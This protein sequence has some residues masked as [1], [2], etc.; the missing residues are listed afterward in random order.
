MI[1]F[2]GQ[3]ARALA[4][5][6]KVARY[7]ASQALAAGDLKGAR[8]QLE[9][10][11]ARSPDDADALTLLAQVAANQQD[12]DEAL[13]LLEAAAALDP[14]PQR[15]AVLVNN[16]QMAFDAAAAL[17]RIERMPESLRNLLDVR[18]L[19]AVLV[20][21]LG[22][23]RRE[24]GIFEVLIRTHG[25]NP[26]VWM[27]YAT[28]LKVAGRTDEAAAAIQRAIEILPTYGEAYWALANF[29]SYRFSDEEVAAMQASLGLGINDFQIMH[30]HFALGV[31]FE[32]RGDYRQAFAHFDAGNR[33]RAAR[34][35]PG[36][37]VV[38]PIV[39]AAIDTLSPTFFETRR[40]HGHP[41]DEPIFVIGLH[42]SGSTLIEQIL[43][44]HPMIEG[45]S[46]LKTMPRL[47]LRLERDANAAGRSIWEEM[48]RLDARALHELGAEYMERTRP[49]RRGSESRFV[50]KLPGNWLQVS[51]IRL[52]FPNAKIIDARRHPMACGLSNFKQNYAAG[53]S[54]S[55]SLQTIGLLYRDY[56]RMMEHL[57]RVQPGA[58]HHVVNERLID[59]FESEVR[60]L[61]DFVGVP[62]DP[63]CLEFHRNKRAVRT[64][65]A[66]QVRRPINS[67]GAKLWRHY[68]PWLGPL[69]QALGPALDEWDKTI[70]A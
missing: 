4:A 14:S 30:F 44:S 39:D 26:T 61:L 50:D 2:V 6:G 56:L 21:D 59:D 20:G 53:M 48:Q 40:G 19:E 18:L 24:L 46:E 11:L 43:A 28:P 70:R 1:G 23:Q 35:P 58:V 8:R 65:S 38:T 12:L 42:R 68:E 15:L 51:L 37:M 63:A 69:K 27:N 66:E 31:A 10:W 7:Y 67:E 29:K 9:R 45:T 16:L 49:Y 33:M 36:L 54:F 47:F 34:T 32:Q 57:D 64:P 41:S 3:Q 13:Q 17:S 52:V 55:Y 22:D 62:F 60:R 5:E 25:D